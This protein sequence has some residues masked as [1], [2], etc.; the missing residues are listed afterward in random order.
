MKTLQSLAIYVAIV[1]MAYAVGWLSGRTSM[2]EQ[3]SLLAGQ[4]EQANQVA[5]EKLA[6]LTFDRDSKQAEINRLAQE[7]EKKDAK[8][9]AEIDRLAGELEHRPVRVRIVTEA[10]ACGSGATGGGAGTAED[11]TEHPGTAD[12]LLPP[13]NTRRLNAAL[14]EIETLSA[15]YNSCRARLTGGRHGG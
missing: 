15:A 4:V 14:T 6:Q 1:L 5:A 10:G 12:G 13:E 9:K 3:Y 2:T 8:A 7:Q 11:R